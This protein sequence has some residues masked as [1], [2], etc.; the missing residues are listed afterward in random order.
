MQCMTLH[1]NFNLPLMLLTHGHICTIYPHTHSCI[2]TQPVI[3]EA[4][5]ATFMSQCKALIEQPDLQALVETLCSHLDTVLAKC[6]ADDT[7][8]TSM[9]FFALL[10]YLEQDSLSPI[11]ARVCELARAHAK[12]DSA[13]ALMVLRNLYSILAPT[14]PSRYVVYLC[15]AKVVEE[16][17]TAGMLSKDLANLETLFVQ[18][19]SSADERAALLVAVARAMSA[20]GEAS[21]A[22][23]FLLRYLR[24]LDGAAATQLNA[25]AAEAS[26]AA[27][28]FIRNPFVKGEISVVNLDAVANLANVPAYAKLYELLRVFAAGECLLVYLVYLVIDSFVLLGGRLW[29]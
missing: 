20:A 14:S 26:K 7:N 21:V 18:W 23:E 27:V 9:L 22:Q 16:S 25:C 5:A 10:R 6:S 17:K 3:G 28:A 12:T 2:H 19:G 24:S 8:N 15:L 29:S 4:K 11:V 1:S 13:V